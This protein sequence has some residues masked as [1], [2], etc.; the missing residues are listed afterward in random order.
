MTETRAFIEEQLTRLEV[1]LMHGAGGVPDR[2]RPRA[3]QTV[4]DAEG[5]ADDVGRRAVDVHEVRGPALVDANAIAVGR[6]QPHARPRLVLRLERPFQPVVD[7][8]V[9]E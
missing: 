6:L 8:P 4:V 7:T 9:L 3:P 1:D 2:E 5:R